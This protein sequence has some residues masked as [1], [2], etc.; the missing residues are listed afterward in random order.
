MH[1][2]DADFERLSDIAI[3]DILGDLGVYVLWSGRAKARPSY[4][5]EGNILRRLV[6]HHDNFPKPF[7]GYAAVLTNGNGPWQR[8]KA[9][10]TI[11]E[12]ML[13]RVA[14]ETDRTPAVNVAAG[15]LRPLD[16]IFQQH[17]TVR[18]NVF[19]LDPLRPPEELPRI[20]GR[21]CIVLRETTDGSIEIEHDWRLRRSRR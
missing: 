19:G 13:L 1:I 9:D 17:G 15:K 18:I 7:D 20:T 21:K 5:G 10:A 14:E 6:T 12:A 3:P 4:I 8:A 16:D 2:I 11:V